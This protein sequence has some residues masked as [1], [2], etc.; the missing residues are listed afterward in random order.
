[1]LAPR[2]KGLDILAS[3]I[4]I[5]PHRVETYCRGGVR[6]ACAHCG[7][8]YLGKK[9]GSQKFVLQAYVFVA[10]GNKLPPCTGS[11]TPVGRGWRSVA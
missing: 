9:E 2:A 1:M 7:P 10:A 6:K 4:V 3:C 5:Y 8:R 11:H